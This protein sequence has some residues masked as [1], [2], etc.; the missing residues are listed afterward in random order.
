MDK[1]Q[2]RHRLLEQY[3]AL[4]LAIRR[5]GSSQICQYLR[6]YLQYQVESYS[7]QQVV[8]AGYWALPWELSLAEF[9]QH[10]SHYP[11]YLPRVIHCGNKTMVF[12]RYEHGVT[13]LT[14]DKVG[15]LAP[16]I[17][18]KSQMEPFMG[19]RGLSDQSQNVL[20]VMLIPA[21][22]VNYQGYRLGYG[23]GYYDR[24]LS[25]LS[26]SQRLSIIK[27]AVVHL[28]HLADRGRSDAAMMCEFGA[29][30]WDVSMDGVLSPRGVH[31]F[32]GSSRD[33]C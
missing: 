33:S 4:N 24:F 12:C 19:I 32:H 25:A 27:L 30:F 3:K 18:H 7:A 2:L 14:R 6:E 8:V 11:L 1:V 9:Y 20:M 29:D 28:D 26:K 17:S 16:S 23:G 5:A 21:L 13:E 31:E 22:A 10:N 15:I